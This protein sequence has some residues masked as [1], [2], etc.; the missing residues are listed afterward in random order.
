MG[1]WCV[2]PPVWALTCSGGGGGRGAVCGGSDPPAK[3]A[4]GGLMGGRS[5]DDTVS[6][7]SDYRTGVGLGRL[8]WLWME[9]GAL[10]TTTRSRGGAG[11]AGWSAQGG[12]RVSI[13]ARLG[14]WGKEG[15]GR[16]REQAGWRKPMA[17]GLWITEFQATMPA[18]LCSCPFNA[19]HSGEQASCPGLWPEA[20][21]A[22][23]VPCVGPPRH[24]PTPQHISKP[25]PSP[26][27]PP[28]PRLPSGSA[29]SRGCWSSTAPTRWR[30]RTWRRGSST[31]R[32]PCRGRGGSRGKARGACTRACTGR[33]GARGRASRASRRSS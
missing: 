33:T 25:P 4:A 12:R 29:P 3:R 24:Q 26:P 27:L 2:E 21:D 15:Q 14:R 23:R 17:R 20:W 7:V 10:G 5:G 28:P 31:T 13:L 8:G 6:V 11:W 18:K 30:P 19:V 22:G 16:A 1:W 9:R 32:P